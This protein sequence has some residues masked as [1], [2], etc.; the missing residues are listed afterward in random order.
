MAET[1]REEER[2]AENDEFT[3][4][5]KQLLVALDCKMKNASPSM[6]KRIFST[7]KHSYRRYQE[8]PVRTTKVSSSEPVIEPNAF[9]YH[10]PDHGGVPKEW[11]SK[12]RADHHAAMGNI[13][14]N[15]EESALQARQ[16]AVREIVMALLKSKDEDQVALS[17]LH[18]LH[19]PQV[20]PF[21]GRIWSTYHSEAVQVGLHAL[22]GME[23]IVR[24]V[25]E[26]RTNGGRTRQCRSLLSII[27]M[28]LAN[29]LGDDDCDISKEALYRTV[30]KSV[31]RVSARRLMKK[32]GQKRKR[33][34][35]EELREFRCVDEEAKR[36]KYNE[37]DIVELRKYMCNNRY[38]KDSPNTKDTVKARDI[39]GEL[40]TFMHPCVSTCD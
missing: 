20:K 33:F 34:E 26:G 4:E 37:S 18:F 30:F 32:A 35:E 39:Y 23:S 12:R 40:C 28:C 21:L 22:Q 19:H 24:M 8:H 38:T 29:R 14:F 17:L 1:R 11:M 3:P 15:E 36:W 25:V 5:T 2:E 31:S 7:V 13:T 10:R 27:G 9:H 6:R 16:G